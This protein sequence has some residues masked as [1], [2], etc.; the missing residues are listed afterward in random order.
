MY[1]FFK[2]MFFHPSRMIIDFFLKM[3]LKYSK[4]ILSN[5]SYGSNVRADLR[6]IYQP[7]ILQGA[8]KNVLRWN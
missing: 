5:F 4:R 1:S 2:I 3:S 8:M 7:K 6:L